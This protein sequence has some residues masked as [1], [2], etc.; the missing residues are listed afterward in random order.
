MAKTTINSLVISALRHAER[1]TADVA[2]L[3]TMLSP[4]VLGDRTLCAD[5]LRAG[6]AARHGIKLNVQGTGRAVFPAEHPSSEAARQDLSRLVKSVRGVSS[7]QKTEKKARRVD[8][9]LLVKV[10]NLISR[11]GLTKAEARDL[12][13]AVVEAAY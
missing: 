11:A 9:D 7:G 8:A 6:V 5:A 2:E 12:F 4:E 1:F 13:A 10:Q 3:R